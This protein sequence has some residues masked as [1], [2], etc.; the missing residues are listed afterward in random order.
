M[1]R[2]DFLKV[3]GAC[4]LPAF[5]GCGLTRI[6]PWHF[7]IRSDRISSLQH[8][9]EIVGKAQLTRTADGRVQVLFVSGEPYERGYQQGVLLRDEINDNLGYIHKLA[10]KKFYFAELFDEAYERMRPYIPEEY[11]EEMHGLAHGARMPVSVIH[12]LHALPGIGEWSGRKKIRKIIKQM[13]R[14]EELGTSC[15]NFSLMGESTKDG[16]MYVVRIL[17]WGLH[18]ISKLHE[19]PLITVNIPDRGIP[20]ANIG[21]AGFLGAV[22]GMNAQG[23]TLGEMGYGDPDNETLRGKPMI[24]L[25]RDVMSYAANLGD[26]RQIIRDSIGTSSFGFMMSDGKT[27]DAELYIRD[28]DRFVPF[29][30]GQTAEDGDELLPGIRDIVYG[31]HYNEKMTKVLKASRGDVSF[32]MI[33]E[34][35]IP[36]F[37]MK[38]N[39]QNVIYQ[40]NK[41]KFWVNNAKSKR[42]W[43]ADQ[44]YSFFDLGEALR[45]YEAG[46]VES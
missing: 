25:L 12:H 21:W 32:D 33:R 38:S 9:R 2:R 11:V 29:R 37:V 13:M 35:L 17:D 34:K 27:G 7:L 8:E 18:R 44:P 30:A 41:L 5:T 16:E 26:V 22:S 39:F 4:S 19:Y 6:D 15:S 31:G 10:L 3:L 20:S 14:G 1:K 23:I 42:E 24:F 28:R 36:E 46:Q 40:P 43:A 45:A